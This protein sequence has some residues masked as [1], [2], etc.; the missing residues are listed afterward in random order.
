MQQRSSRQKR[1]KKTNEE[2]KEE[3]ETGAHGA[4]VQRRDLD[5]NFKLMRRRSRTGSPVTFIIIVIIIRVFTKIK[6]SVC[7]YKSSRSP[8][9]RRLSL[10]FK[11]IGGANRKL[12][13]EPC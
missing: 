5:Q 2:E 3:E 7:F 9:A 10:F 12:H 6:V 4:E 11:N 13:K 1:K 8:A